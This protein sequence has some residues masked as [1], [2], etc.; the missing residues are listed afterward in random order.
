MLDNPRQSV[1]AVLESCLVAAIAW[2]N[3]FF[4]PF[5]F[6]RVFF[7]Y[8]H[9]TEKHF[10]EWTAEKKEGIIK[11]AKA[12]S[13]ASCWPRCTATKTLLWTQ[14]GLELETSR[15]ERTGETCIGTSTSL[16]IYGPPHVT[17]RHFFFSFSGEVGMSAPELLY[18]VLNKG[19]VK[20][21]G[22]G[23]SGDRGLSVKEVSWLLAGLRLW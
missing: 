2:G 11:I 19:W 18:L 15:S 13:T 6:L 7:F 16:L 3:I 21:G 1:P 8:G 9:H 22:A 5:S 12:H 23:V 10:N 20:A 4:L 14:A 17:A